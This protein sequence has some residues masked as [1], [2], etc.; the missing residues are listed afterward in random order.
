[1]FFFI[2]FKVDSIP[3]L[4]DLGVPLDKLTDST[5]VFFSNFYGS[6]EDAFFNCELNPTP[7]ERGDVPDRD[8]DAPPSDEFV[9]LRK[10]VISRDTGIG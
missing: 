10:G 8:L 6:F 5:N 9:Y 1:M 2:P 3:L 7:N 4:V